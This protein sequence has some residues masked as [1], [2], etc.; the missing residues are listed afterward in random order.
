MDRFLKAIW[1]HFRNRIF[2]SICNVDFVKPKCIIDYAWKCC[3]F[4]GALL[5]HHLCHLPFWPLPLRHSLFAL[6]PSSD[7]AACFGA[8]ESQQVPHKRNVKKSLSLLHSV[9]SL[10]WEWQPCHWLLM[11]RKDGRPEGVTPIMAIRVSYVTHNEIWM[12]SKSNEKPETCPISNWCLSNE[13]Y[14]AAEG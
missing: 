11:K 6:V 3:Y 5:S 2:V 1:N 10:K 14:C 7:T 9:P 12:L 8:S 13:V 4:L